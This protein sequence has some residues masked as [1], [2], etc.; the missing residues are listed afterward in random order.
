[1]I[2]VDQ[3]LLL[4][5]RYSLLLLLDLLVFRVRLMRLM[6]LSFLRFLVD[7]SMRL[8]LG[9]ALF[10]CLICLPLDLLKIMLINMLFIIDFLILLISNLI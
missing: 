2:V 1:M 8:G 5:S 7:I 10:G 4:L 9:S 3:M 6:S